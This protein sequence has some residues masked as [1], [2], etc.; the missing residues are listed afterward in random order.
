[1]LFQ[2]L[3]LTW[4]LP[5]TSTLNFTG[6]PNLKPTAEICYRTMAY[7]PEDNRLRPDLRLGFSDAAVR[8]VASVV[9]WFENLAG[10]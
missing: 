7:S 8:K 6:S 5:T 2:N 1:V 4:E 10:L 9:S 3:L